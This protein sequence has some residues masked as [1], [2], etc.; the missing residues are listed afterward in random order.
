V[1]LI[2]VVCVAA[3]GLV[4]FG[5][6][7]GSTSTT[8]RA[9]HWEG[10][11]PTVAFDITADGQI[12]NWHMTVPY[13]GSTCGISAGSVPVQSDHTIAWN[14][15][16]AQTPSIGELKGTFNGTTVS[17]TYLITMCSQ[18]VSYVH[19]ED[20]DRSWSAEWKSS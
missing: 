5:G 17:G 19:G 14:L 12:A 2:V 8:P 6:H 7:G 10:S 3:W 1:A 18:S 4:V 16:S 20:T 13:G 11:S 9:G 15:S